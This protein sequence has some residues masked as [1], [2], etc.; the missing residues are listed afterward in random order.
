MPKKTSRNADADI[1]EFD[2]AELERSMQ[3]LDRELDAMDET[4]TPSPLD[5]IPPQGGLEAETKA[6]LSATLKAF[7]DR[8][9]EER[10]QMLDTCDSEYWFC[11]CFQ[12]RDQ[13][14]AFLK[15]MKWFEHGDKYLDGTYLAKRA[16]IE[17]P[18][19]SVRFVGQKTDAKLS[20][21][22]KQP[23]K[24]KKKGGE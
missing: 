19:S 22:G 1:P 14:E 11:V 12:S 10:K 3:R 21:A 17:L 18:P 24:V 8:K 4:P 15:A 2:D 6:E 23:A 13:K 5:A 16:G 20:Q 7:K 9:A